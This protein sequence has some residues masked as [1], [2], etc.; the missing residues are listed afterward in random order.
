MGKPNWFQPK[1]QHVHGKDEIDSERWKEFL[2]IRHT[3]EQAKTQQSLEPI[4]LQP[5][6]LGTW[7]GTKG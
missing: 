7:P 2:A 1:D 4:L 3:K 5:R 6:N